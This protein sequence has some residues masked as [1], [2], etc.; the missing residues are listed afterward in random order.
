ME[1]Q[2][3]KSFNYLYYNWSIYATLEFQSSDVIL[4]D[5]TN[6]KY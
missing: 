1:A 6:I 2:P 5:K 4:N 3:S